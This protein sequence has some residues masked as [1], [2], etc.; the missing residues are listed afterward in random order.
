MNAKSSIRSALTEF[1]N[2]F[3]KSPIKIQ[4]VQ[5][6]LNIH[7]AVNTMHHTN[8]IKNKNYK[9]ISAHAEKAVDKNQHSLHSSKNSFENG[10]ESN[11]P[12]ND[13]SHMTDPQKT[14]Y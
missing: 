14:S 1:S 13:K 12:Q 6:W 2:T 5:E 11:L 4:L 3:T 10:C 9:L 7:K 8:K